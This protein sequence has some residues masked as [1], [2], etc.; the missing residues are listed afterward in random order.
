MAYKRATDIIRTHEACLHGLT[1]ALLEKETLTSDE[2]D[3]I[4]ASYT[5]ASSVTPAVPEA[6]VAVSAGSS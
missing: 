1:Q 4:V 6:A 3:A 5:A 2:V